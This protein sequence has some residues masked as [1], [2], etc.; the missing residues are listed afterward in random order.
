ML[1]RSEKRWVTAEADPRV[2]E[3]IARTHGFSR[4]MARALVTRG[5]VDHAEI[6][7]F[8]QPRLADL[9]DPFALPGM[10]TAVDL[11][12]SH[13]EQGSAILVYGDY[14]V[15]GV[16]ATALM[17]QVLSGL[18]AVAVPFLP[19]R[20]EDGYGLG[21][22]TLHRCIEN[23]HP[24]LIITVDC[25]TSSVE[26]VREAARLGIDVIVTDHHEPAAEGVAEACAIVNPKLGGG[27]EE[28]RMLAGV[29]VAFKVCHGLVKAARQRRMEAAEK[30]DL[31]TFM[32]LV[33]VGTVADIVPLLKENRILVYHGLTL[34]NR[35]QSVGLRTLIEAAGISGYVDT[36][37][38]G[39]IIGP[40]INAAGRLGN[41]EAALEL[42]LTEQEP[43]ARIL[44]QQLD[45]ASRKRQEIEDKIVQEACGD[46][47]GRFDAGRDFGL[48]VAHP[49]WHAG[50]IGIV[51]SR[52]ASRYNRPVVVI[53]MDDDGV[54]RG[55]CRSV[56]GFDL[57][58]HLQQC[59]SMLRRYGGHAMAAGLEVDHS[60]IEE[61]A[62]RFNE[63]C[64]ATLSQVDQ[65]RQLLVDAW[66]TP[67]DIGDPLYH[68]QN[69]LRPF[70]H[71]NPLPVWAIRNVTPLFPPRVIGGKH[72][73]ILF[74]MGGRQREAIGFGMGD[75]EV[76]DGPLDI[77]FNLI[78]NRYNGQEYLQ[79][80]LQ[81]LRPTQ[82]AE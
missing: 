28:I 9:T 52:I 71:S 22:E 58:K 34:L 53:G 29:G 75:R 73:K 14:D 21:V 69:R 25:G 77:A 19:H 15:D 79:L 70:G 82:H 64:A 44:A 65:R 11:I 37:H 55:S 40:R 13:I 47:D 78:L 16:T 33:A 46:L 17:I 74:S 42:V 2:A 32:E 54:G 68:D 59:S 81:D 62:A 35:T 24:N 76:P 31:K 43:R 50:V 57:L 6:E 23:Y 38:I 67:G 63:V 5:L 7:K 36:Y 41:A 72:L 30:L 3:D 45:D 26:A 10:Q 18:G 48:V 60:R 51:A 1:V 4:A 66:I 20:I 80:H 61:F 56:P 12:L 49:H 39:F 8:L 27:P